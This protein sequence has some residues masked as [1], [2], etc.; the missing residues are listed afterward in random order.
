MLNSS[1][2]DYYFGRWPAEAVFNP[3]LKNGYP[4]YIHNIPY[5]HAFMPTAP[6]SRVLLSA[7]LV[8]KKKVPYI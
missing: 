2:E 5:L 1:R 4:V 7:S 3:K 8:K 6:L